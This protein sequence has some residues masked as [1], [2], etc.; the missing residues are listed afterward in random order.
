MI[1]GSNQYFF[2]AQ[3]NTSNGR[4]IFSLK[5]QQTTPSESSCK[6]LMVTFRLTTNYKLLRFGIMESRHICNA[7]A[8]LQCVNVSTSMVG[9][10]ALFFS[11]PFLCTFSVF[12][13]LCHFQSSIK[14]TVVF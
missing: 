10:V 11:H 14:A 12:A 4:E 7:S 2:H 6:V 5:E 3:S 9:G 13:F 8:R 1:K